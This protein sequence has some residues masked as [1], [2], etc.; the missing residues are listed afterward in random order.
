MMVPATP[1]ACGGVAGLSESGG[2]V[3]MA[4]VVVALPW[5]ELGCCVGCRRVGPVAALLALDLPGGGWVLTCWGCYRAD[6]PGRWR[7]LPVVWDG[8]C[9]VSR[10]PDTPKHHSLGNDPLTINSISISTT[11]P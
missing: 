6:P 9:W 8:E 7:G 5:V 4:G 10:L 1:T 2:V 11:Q 3:M